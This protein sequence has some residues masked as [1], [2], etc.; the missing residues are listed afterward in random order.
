MSEK[1]IRN[2]IMNEL[3][4][5]PCLLVLPN[6][7]GVA[8][9]VDEE[10]GKSYTVTYGLGA[11]KGGGGPDL[12]VLIHWKG[13]CGVRGCQAVGIEVKQPGE[14]PRPNQVAWRRNAARWGMRIG[15]ASTVEMATTL[16]DYQK[17][18]LRKA[19]L[20][21]CRAESFAISLPPGH[22]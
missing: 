3:G 6:P 17:S 19:G 11:I 10:T 8:Q 16:I 21:P 7:T 14:Q 5:D 4:K 22:W 18:E 12:V 20:E 9:Y 13:A 15:V 2:Q 1:R